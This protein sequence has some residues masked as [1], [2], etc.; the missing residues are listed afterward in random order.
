MSHAFYAQA[1]LYDLMFPGS[2]PA[3]DFFRAEAQR[4]GGRVLEL[5]C[6]T[7][8]KL[9]PIAADG[10][11]CVGL[12]SSPEML[13]EARRK[14]KE[15]GVAVAWAEGDMRDFDLDSTFDLVF[16]TGNSLLH[17][18]Q[19]QDLV[20]C[21]QSVRRHLA[22]GARFLFDVFNPSVRVCRSRWRTAYPAPAYRA[23][24]PSARRAIRRL[25][26]A[27]VRCGLSD[28]TLHLRGRL[29][30]QRVT[31]PSWALLVT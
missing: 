29:I 30:A 23:R 27:A 11:P 28:P 6:G 17:L 24:R 21:F 25:V 1:R 15:H 4:K 14:A 20:S 31:R 19:A 12:D 2:G 7:G 8:Q 26:W 22:A 13:A 16:N 5:G 18:Q 3:V 10:H 9:I